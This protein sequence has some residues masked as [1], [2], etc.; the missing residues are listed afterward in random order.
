MAKII[1]GTSLGTITTIVGTTIQETIMEETTSTLLIVIMA[2][3]G[4]TDNG[5]LIPIMEA[6]LLITT[7]ITFNMFISI[8]MMITKICLTMM[9]HTTMA[10]RRSI[11]THM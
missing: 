6:F 10:F 2:S 8:S 9:V 7:T 5:T 4:K 1:I 11:K 3:K